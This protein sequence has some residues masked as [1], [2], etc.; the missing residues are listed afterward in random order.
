MNP[1]SSPDPKAPFAE[2]IQYALTHEV[3]WTRDPHAEPDRWGVHR[4]DP[5]PYNRLFGPVHARG[6]V[7]GLV[8]QQG[9]EVCRWGTPERAD[10]TF[11][12]AKTYLALLAGVAC[13]D[14]LLPDP[15]R[16]VVT[17]LPGIGFDDPHNRTITWRHLLT[18]VSE[19]EGECL[20]LPDTVDRYRHVAHDPKKVDGVK[21]SA[22]PLQAPGS[23][24]E[25][26]DVRINQ[27][28]LALLHL[29]Q[30]ALPRVFEREIL[31]PLGA[32]EGFA[33]RGYDQAWV[34]WPAQNGRPAQRVQSVPG[35][36]HWGAGVSISTIDQARVGQL[37]LQ[38]GRWDA[39]GQTRQILPAD[40]V[41]DM[42]RPCPLAPF[43][44]MLTW[45][46]PQGSNFPGTSEQALFMVGAGGNYVWIEPALDAV[47]V[48]RWLDSAHFAGFCERMTQALI[49]A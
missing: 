17:Q 21:G 41:R 44:G 18:Q 16:P 31:Q 12:V 22:R 43:Y 19:W 27:L 36:T 35:G 2:A 10:L 13:R 42:T 30:E 14:G 25:Y 11:S 38:G 9:R 15:D 26:N 4:E 48:V 23:Y 37:L 29:F 49:G 46:N 24:W 45:L 20:G 33:W 32:G 8:L 34:E 47:V 7:S 5:P 28:S 40:W 6:G 1:L 39:A 3:D